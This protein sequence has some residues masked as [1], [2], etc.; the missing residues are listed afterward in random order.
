M[1]PFE[2]SDPATVDD[3]LAQLGPGAVPKAGGIDVMDRLKERL[4][5]AARLVNLRN[6]P[7]LDGVHARDGFVEV[8][9]AQALPARAS[10]ASTRG[11]LMGSSRRRTPVAL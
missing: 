8:G 7:G 10:A 5:D 4:D 6:I 9:H 3:A 2:W 1:R 11:G